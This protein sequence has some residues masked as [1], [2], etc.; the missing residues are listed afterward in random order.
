MFV[1][2]FFGLNALPVAEDFIGVVC[3][4]VAEDV[5]VSAYEFVADGPNNVLDVELPE[6]LSD[7][8][9]EHDL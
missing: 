3:G 8:G 9:N 4:S 6:L 5:R 7:R 2:A 1:A